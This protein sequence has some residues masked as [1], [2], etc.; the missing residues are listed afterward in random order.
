MLPHVGFLCDRVR[1]FTEHNLMPLDNK[2]G[3]RSFGWGFWGMLVGG[4]PWGSPCH[5][6]H[7]LVPSLPWYEQLVLHRHLARLLTPKQRQQFLLEPVVGF[8]KLWWK[9]VR[10]TRQ[11]AETAQRT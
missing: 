4:G 6:E 5:W 8:P 9:L 7:H 2:N 10:E 1:Q 3:S 11:F